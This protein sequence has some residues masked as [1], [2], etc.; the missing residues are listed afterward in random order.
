M[1]GTEVEMRDPTSIRKE[2]K[3]VCEAI[4]KLAERGGGHTPLYEDSE[5]YLRL[6][7]IKNTLEWVHPVLIKIPK[8]SNRYSAL[9]GHNHVLNGPTHALLYP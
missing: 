3:K 7:T 8:G 2:Y 5:I 1:P 4:N 9:M 6:S